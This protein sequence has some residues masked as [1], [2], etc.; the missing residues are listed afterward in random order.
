M[1]KTNTIKRLMA[2]GAVTTSLLAVGGVTSSA[3]AAGVEVPGVG[4]AATC[5]QGYTGVVG[6]SGPTGQFWIC[7]NIV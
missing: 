5:P 4:S 2:V 3:F 1:R 6:D 7:Q